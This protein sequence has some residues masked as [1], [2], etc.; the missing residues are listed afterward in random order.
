MATFLATR[1][2]PEIRLAIATLEVLFEGLDDMQARA[3][4]GEG[5]GSHGEGR[6]APSSKL[7]PLARA[8]AAS[9]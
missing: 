6:G 4:T 2:A 7:R 8:P 5:S 3:R 1:T 9:T